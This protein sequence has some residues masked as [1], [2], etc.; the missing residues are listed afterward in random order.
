M[1]SQLQTHQKGGDLNSWSVLYL[2][3]PSILKIPTEQ[4]NESSLLSSLPSSFPVSPFLCLLVS[5]VLFLSFQ[6]SNVNQAGV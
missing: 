4:M 5:P 2:W 3:Y 1:E 6:S